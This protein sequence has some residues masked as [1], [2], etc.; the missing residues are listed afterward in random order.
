MSNVVS[1]MNA[2]GKADFRLRSAYQF[3]VRRI[4]LKIF[5][6]LAIQLCTALLAF[7]TGTAAAEKTAT[8]IDLVNNGQKAVAVLVVAARQ[9][10]V[11]KEQ[12]AKTK[13]FW[14]ATKTLSESFQ[15][16]S[17]SL[18]SQE[19]S[20]FTEL[21]TA[22]AAAQQGK[23]ALL[24]IDGVGDAVFQRM[25]S[26][27]AVVRKLDENYNREASCL[28]S[29]GTL[30]ADERRQLDELRTQKQELQKKL[31]SVDRKLSKND[32]RIRQG[33][34]D[35][36]ENSQGIRNTGYR[37]A[38]LC[39]SMYATRYMVGALWAWHWWWGPWGYWGPGYI[40]V[41]ID[42]WDTWADAYIY[43]W[44]LVDTAIAVDDL[45][46]EKLAIEDDVLA[47][48]ESWLDQ[49]EF[50]LLESD[51]PDLTYHVPDAGWDE[52]ETAVGEEVM[53]GTQSNFEQRLFEPEFEVD[54][55]QDMGGFDDFGG[56]FGGFDW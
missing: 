8:A 50:T 28:A 1:K 6:T 37:R 41:S 21:S 54:T 19:N 22:V 49:N 38:D 48:T 40:S 39:N 24:M 51:M 36:R 34:D 30:T 45:E 12:S 53:R 16:M 15:Q 44:A 29:G 10:T 3:S 18:E 55:F 27:E 52:V 31:D 9:D 11:L 33:I 25:E 14:E 2:I 26:V 17:L 4:K 43:D 47:E 20:L 42:L 32:E 5:R 13:P 7:S 35:I 23:V 56:D 46:L